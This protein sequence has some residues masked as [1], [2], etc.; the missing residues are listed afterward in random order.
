[1]TTGGN[2]LSEF[3]DFVEGTGPTY[4]TGPK[5]LVNEAVKNTYYF[6]RLMQGDVAATKMIQ[7]GSDIR[8]SI[9]F[10]DNGTHEYYAPG[11]NHS[12]KN[13][14]R[15]EKIRAYWRFSM[16]HMSWTEQEILLN[17]RVAYGTDTARF[18]QYVDI[19]NEKELLMWTAKW[20]G[21]ET[22]LWKEP[23]KAKMEGEGAGFTEPYSIPA[24]INEDTDGLFARQ[25]SGT[26]TVV[27][28][29]D[30]TA[31][32]VDGKFT[33]QQLTYDS[34]TLN[35]AGN[36]LSM[37]DEMFQDVHFEQPS[38]H[39]QYWEDPRLNKQMILTTKVGRKAIMVLLRAGNTG[40]YV[41]GS[42]D[43][44]YPDPLYNGIPVARVSELEVAT[45]YD[46]GS[47]GNTT[48]DTSA[49]SAIAGP[50]FYWVN[51]NYLYPVFHRD[52]YFA[53]HEVT[54]HHNVP[55]TWVCPIATWYNVICTSR[56]RQGILSPSTDLYYA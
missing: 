20:N 55:D 42:Q 37:F 46:D 4:V 52:R 56:Q 25:S 50:R 11:A 34:E 21:M 5:S 44:A 6:G 51:G 12:W 40:G 24:F 15:L 41:T 28:G 13:P 22:Q 36:P 1:M 18:H 7:G 8:E 38:M 43:A 14:Q 23:D 10:R 3:N 2:P 9:V 29:I 33:P 31:S 19:R 39:K 47:S 49:G 35:D 26:W 27:E 32:D 45:L 16:A 48:E 30:P 53:K 17:E 54:K